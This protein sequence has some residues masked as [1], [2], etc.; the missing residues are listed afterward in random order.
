MKI[1]KILAALLVLIIVQGCHEEYLQDK[2]YSIITEDNYFKNIERCF[3]S[4][5]WH[6]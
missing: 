2:A 4:R 3:D 5:E 6:I 1:N